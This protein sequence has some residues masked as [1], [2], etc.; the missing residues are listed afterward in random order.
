MGRSINDRVYTQKGFSCQNKSQHRTIN[1][2]TNRVLS[3]SFYKIKL[4]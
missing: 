1:R 3:T 4:T 2:V